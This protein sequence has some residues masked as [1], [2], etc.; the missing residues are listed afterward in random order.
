MK[1]LEQIFKGIGIASIISTAI[2]LL[3][4]LAAGSGCTPQKRLDR[5]VKKHPHL[6]RIDTVKVT[7]TFT[8]MVPGI[9]AD[10]NFTKPSFLDA[11]KDTIILKKEQLTVKIY[12]YRDS[13]FIDAKCDTV[14][15]TVIREVRVPYPTVTPNTKKVLD[16]KEKLF[17]ILFAVLAGFF[18]AKTKLWN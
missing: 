9:R 13:V 2:V 11:L 3:M 17:W 7:D 6:S 16:W 15:K 4:M 12:E 5:L 8:V 1:T 14:Y 18:L 10:T